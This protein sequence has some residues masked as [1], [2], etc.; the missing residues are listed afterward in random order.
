[1]SRPKEPNYF[2][3]DEVYARGPAW[4]ASL[5]EAAAE[6]QLRGESS[7]HYTKLPTHPRTV[8]RMARDVPGVKILYVTRHPIDRLVSHYVHE[9]SLESVPDSI[10][11]AIDALP[12]LVE[13]G[14]YSRQIGPYLDVFGAANV[15][16]VFFGRLVLRP[17]A[18][19]ERICRFIGL[20]DRAALG[21]VAEAPERRAGAAAEE[22]DPRDPGSGPRPDR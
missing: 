9:R 13:Y 19:L 2:S 14:L 3:D 1:M 21:H 22:R 16:P 12:E 5:F 10:E 15:L 6:G 7:T 11:R 20:R 18:A 8:E 17:E 4:Y